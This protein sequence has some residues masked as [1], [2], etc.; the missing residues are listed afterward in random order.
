MTQSENKR[1]TGRRKLQPGIDNDH[2]EFDQD[3]AKNRPPTNG[4]GLTEPVDATPAKTRQSD[5]V[6]GDVKRAPSADPD[7]SEVAR[8]RPL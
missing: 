1:E 5:G 3:A 8:K 6:D 2:P 7:A 4:V